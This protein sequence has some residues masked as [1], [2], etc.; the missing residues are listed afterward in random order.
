MHPEILRD[1]PGDCPKCGMALEPVI[2]SDDTSESTLL[3]KRFWISVILGIPVVI[4]G[5]GPMV[6]MTFLHGQI[7]GWVEFLFSIPVVFWCGAEIWMK[8]FRSFATGAL[9]MF[10]LI[11]LGTG[12]AFLYSMTKLF[13]SPFMPTYSPAG[14]Y[15]FEAATM[16]MVLVLMGQWLESK[17][18]AKAGSA[19]RE[20]L[21]LT[22]P[23]ALLVGKEG[24]ADHEIPISELKEGDHLRVLPGGKIPADGIVLEG[25]S[26]IDESMLTGEPLPMEKSPGSHV[27]AGTIN[28]SG[29][30]VVQVAHSG[31]ETT[32]SQIISLVAQAQRSQAPIQQTADRVAA[33]FVPMVIGVSVFTFMIWMI[34]GPAPH[35]FHALNAAVAVIMIACPCALG[36][37]TPMA[38]IVGVGKAAQEGILVRSASALQNLASTNL[39]AL[40]KT[41]TLTEGKPKLVSIHTI[42]PFVEK[43]LLA[44]ASGAEQGSE[45]PLAR[46]LLLHA[47]DQGIPILKSSSFKAFPGGGISAVVDEKELLLG[48]PQFLKGRGMPLE[49]WNLISLKPG[50]GLVAIAVGG[51]PAGAFIFRDTIRDS[52]KTVIQKLSALGVRTVMLTGDATSTA[53]AVARELGIT[54]FYAE[55]SPSAKADHFTSWKREGFHAAM[56][57]DG[58]NDAPALA[59]AETSIAMGLGSDIAKETAGIILLNPSLEGIVSSIKIS[60]EILK[61]IK[62][63]LFFAFAYNILCIPIAAGI[64]YP[65]FGLLLS[66]M[67]AAA[68]MS[69]S[70][71]SVIANSLRLRRIR[72]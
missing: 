70:S 49:Q 61:V 17:G 19:L 43:N 20:L 51:I 68:A 56:V 8:G 26:S 3:K 16:I 13:L 15:Y 12:A 1:K 24:E 41:G 37:A 21:D 63:N 35:F 27:S 5:M 38:L 72:F 32:L 6:G 65:L 11:T 9:N 34:A 59:V 10:S 30:L 36:L 7:A 57:G 42:D 62:E 69:L 18:R 23:M 58:I 22:P 46:A 60:R 45:H 53:E 66:P 44:L 4:L 2:P 29:S 67:L 31:A 28:A 54:R 50:E 52:A 48:T 64:F 47:Q 39:L 55:L 25:E 71:L 14:G 33:I 40:D